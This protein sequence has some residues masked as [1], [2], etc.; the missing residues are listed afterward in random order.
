MDWPSPADRLAPVRMV[1]DL[2]ANYPPALPR[3][4]TEQAADDA[5]DVHEL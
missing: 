4:D 2:R 3:T 5:G 1:G